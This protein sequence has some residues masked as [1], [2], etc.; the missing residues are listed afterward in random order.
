MSIGREHY[1]PSLV[2]TPMSLCYFT[3][4]LQHSDVC[5]LFRCMS[6]FISYIRSNSLSL[7]YK[8]CSMN[9]WISVSHHG[10]HDPC[11]HDFLTCLVLCTHDTVLLIS[12][13]IKHWY[14]P[15]T[16]F[17]D[18]PLHVILYSLHLKRVLRDMEV[19]KSLFHSTLITLDLPYR[20]SLWLLVHLGSGVDER[21][22]WKL[23]IIFL[24]AYY[25][26]HSLSPR[27]LLCHA[28]KF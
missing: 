8:S 14:I 21:I 18:K 23:P 2:I 24:K 4:A 13:I 12:E 20:V 1:H 26:Y 6:I 5:T 16:N 3:H 27:I 19:S 11:P 22:S 10:G 15:R 9:L 17:S 7:K 25:S 28:I